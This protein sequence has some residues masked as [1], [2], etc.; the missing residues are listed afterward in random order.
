MTQ[1]NLI[2]LAAGGSAALL[3]GAWIFQMFGYPPCKLCLWQRWPHAAAAL[4][5]VIA[6]WRPALFLPYLGALAA[7]AT[8]AVGIYHTGVER[9]WWQGPDTC[10]SGDISGLSAKELMDQILTAPLVQCDVVAWEFL[11]L[12]MATWNAILSFI[13]V[14]IWLAAAQRND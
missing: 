13:L 14:A 6:L 10:T 7:L 3:I 12:S 8:G 2:L 4:I 5:G 9:G 11:S 1:R